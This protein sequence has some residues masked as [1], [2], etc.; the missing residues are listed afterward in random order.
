MSKKSLPDLFEAMYHGKY[1]LD[2]FLKGEVSKD[3]IVFTN[4]EKNKER[5]IYKPNK[6]LKTYHSFLNL[7]SI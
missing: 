4:K 7:F 1:S 5:T 3:F 6:K 2:D